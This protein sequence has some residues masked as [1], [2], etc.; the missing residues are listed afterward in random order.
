MCAPPVWHGGS[1]QHARLTGGAKQVNLFPCLNQLDLVRSVNLLLL[2][3]AASK[4][5]LVTQYV[6][7]I[8]IHFKKNARITER[9]VWYATK[10]I[11]SDHKICTMEVTLMKKKR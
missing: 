10:M 6:V 4:V 7:R 8:A 1:V 2:Q 5:Q 11:E 3:S 9:Q